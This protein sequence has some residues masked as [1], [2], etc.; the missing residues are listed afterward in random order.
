MLAG[1][2][3]RFGNDPSIPKEIYR[4]LFKCWIRNS[5]K[6]V[7]ADEVLVYKVDEEI[8]G[9]AT[10]K[11]EGDKGYAPLLAVKREYEGKGVSFA[12]MRAIETRL[13][14]NNCKYVL[15]G[16]QEINKK[17]LATFKRYGLK[18]QPAEFIY[19]LWRK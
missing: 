11:V 17:A 5:V 2:N 7:I 19:H 8:V 10:I 6:K 13:I 4:E 18:P 1:E 15:S 3:G 14:E 9:F 16:T 12:L